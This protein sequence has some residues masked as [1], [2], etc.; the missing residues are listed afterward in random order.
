MNKEQL[1]NQALVE[2]IS[3]LTANYE[4]KVADLRVEITQLTQS[5]NEAN[6]E[7]DGLRNELAERNEEADD[8][9]VL[10]GEVE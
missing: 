6:Q 2:S 7:L 9:E 10:Q 3:N 5:L 4:N 1:K 8:D